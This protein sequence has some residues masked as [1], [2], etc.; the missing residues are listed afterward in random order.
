PTLLGIGIVDDIA[1][2]NDCFFKGGAV[3]LVGETKREFGGSLYSKIM[4][5][6][7]YEVPKTSPEKL[8][9]YS[10]ALLE[11][12]KKFKVSACHDVS[13]GGVAVAIA[14]MCFG[15]DIGFLANRNFDFVDLFSES[16]TRWIV[17]VKE[18]KAQDLVEFMRKKGLRAE[19]IGF[20]DGEKIDFKSFACDVSEAEEAWRRGMSRF[21]F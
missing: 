15:L 2:V 21:L 3:V 14:E 1:F 17:E 19:I 9:N 8:K 16:N 6:E 11:A 13:E 12:F 5:F 20:S 7:N 4:G 10:K 18:N